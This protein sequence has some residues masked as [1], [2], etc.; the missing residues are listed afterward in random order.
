MMILREP[1]LVFIKTKKTA[2]SSIE[3]ALSAKLQDG[4]FATPFGK[5]AELQ[6]PGKQ[7][8]VRRSVQLLRERAKGEVQ[9]RYPH[10]GIGVVNRY[11]SDIAE[12]CSSICVE[13]NPWDKAVSAFY[14]WMHQR[15][16]QINDA[17][18][19]FLSFCR[20]R[21]KF[22]S[23]FR[24]YSEGGEIAVDRVLRYESLDSDLAQVLDDFG[25]GDVSLGDKRLNSGIRKSKQFDVFYGENWD[26]EAVDLVADLFRREIDAF[27]Y[28]LPTAEEPG[29]V[30]QTAS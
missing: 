4:D 10:N 25:L 7:Y 16:T 13:R 2:G 22:F 1:K 30:G 8:I 23:D 18:A 6:R 3:I 21:L 29:A 14:F 26:G 12:G 20:T 11:L 9:A 19:L 5:E 15:G 28:K 27:G 17:N 24:L